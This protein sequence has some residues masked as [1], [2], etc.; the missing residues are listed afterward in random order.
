MSSATARLFQKTLEPVPGRS[1]LHPHPIDG[2][3]NL[4]RV[5]EIKGFNQD[6]QPCALPCTA[7]REY[8]MRQA[9]PPFYSYLSA[10]K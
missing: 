3:R 8:C 7:L 4:L 9:Q 1:R 10:I 6:A 5:E 2:I